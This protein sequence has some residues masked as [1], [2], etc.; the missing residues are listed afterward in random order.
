MIRA[1]RAAGAFESEMLRRFSILKMKSAAA[2]G[3][4]PNIFVRAAR[5][6][7]D[8]SRGR[9][10]LYRFRRFALIKQPTIF[11]ARFGA[12]PQTPAAVGFQ[13][14]NEIVA[15]LTDDFLNLAV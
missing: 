2:I 15:W 12:G 6:R 10:G 14:V 11:R 4:D 13:R 9:G 1:E 7:H 5:D 3:A 8:R